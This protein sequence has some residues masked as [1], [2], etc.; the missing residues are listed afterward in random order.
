ML[1]ISVIH[2]ALCAVVG[3]GRQ[4]KCMNFPLHIH[5]EAAITASQLNVVKFKD[6]FK[7]CHASRLTIQFINSTHD[8]RRSL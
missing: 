1:M 4:T 8:I 6:S 2:V 7:P 5:V 3:S